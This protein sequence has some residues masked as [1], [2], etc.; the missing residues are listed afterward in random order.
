MHVAEAVRPSSTPPF[1]HAALEPDLNLNEPTLNI[2]GGVVRVEA[3]LDYDG[4][5]ELE[6]Q[7]KALRMILKP[8]RSA[9]AL[10][11]SDETD[12]H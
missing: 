1:T 12:E 6:N 10:L 2:R 3:L 4:L 9:P 11:S 8:R 7:I 5:A